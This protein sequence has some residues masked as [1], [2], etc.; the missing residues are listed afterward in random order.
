M[1]LA[2]S[3]EEVDLLRRFTLLLALIC[4][5][6]AVCIAG[7]G[8]SS[9]SSSSAAS[10]G[11][12]TTSSSAASTHFAKTKFVL[13]AGLAFGAFHHW[14]YKP[15]RAG[16]LRHPF[17]HK[18]TLIKAGLASAFVYHELKLAAEDV[19]SSPTLSKLFSPLTAAADKINSL[20]SSITNGSANESD[21]NNINSQLGNISSTASAHGQPITETTPS[22]SQLNAGSSSS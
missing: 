2:S 8:S 4:C 15:I 6:C 1:L 18:V 12:V 20:K 10:S 5:I 19:K 9:S 3:A 14:I 21:I 11:A 22:L 17:S 16:D 7:C 13:H